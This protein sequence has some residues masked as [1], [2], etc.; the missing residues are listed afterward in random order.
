[1]AA[2]NRLVMDECRACDAAMVGAL[3]DVAVDAFLVDVH[4]RRWYWS[5]ILTERTTDKVPVASILIDYID[6]KLSFESWMR[7]GNNPTDTNFNSNN[8]NHGR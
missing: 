6:Y 2:T 7:N 3:V 1:M 4:A 5:E 8:E